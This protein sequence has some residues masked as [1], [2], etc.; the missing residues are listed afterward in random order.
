MSTAEM[1]AGKAAPVAKGVAHP[2]EKPAPAAVEPSTDIIGDM[3]RGEDKR[4][5]FIPVTRQALMERLARQQYWPGNEAQHVRRFFRYLDYWRKQTY[6]A[7][8]LD[9]EQTYEP[10]SPDSDLLI[11][12][13]FNAKEKDGMQTRLVAQCEQLLVQAN[14]TKI[15]P[16]N[17]ELIMTK[18]SHY[19]L[20]LQVDFTAFDELAIYFR[21][22]TM[23]KEHRR[24]IKKLYLWKEE[25]DVPIFQRICIL[26]KM[27]PEER[28]IRDLM[29][30]QKCTEEQATKVVKRLR[31]SLPPQVKPDYVYLKLFKNMPRS[32]VEM[33]FPNTKVKFRL[34]DKMK[35]GATAGSGLGM[36]IFGTA[37]KIAV[38]TNPIA[39]AGA[40]AGLGGIAI[41][42]G[43]NFMNQKTKYMVTMA[44]NLYFHAMADNR[45]VMTLLADRASEEDVKEEIL[46]YSVLAKQT[47]NRNSLAE[48]DKSI[49]QYLLNTFG[50]NLN[51]DVEDALQRL[52]QDGIVTELADGT[53]KT[54]PPAAAAVHI[55]VL[56]DKY[57]D[58]LPD[59]TTTEGVEFELESEATA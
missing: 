58:E 6:S 50:L 55:D 1:T 38:A 36:G 30:K 26:F 22:A 15:D 41:R 18:D 44:Q 20:D 13:K 9:L 23:R 49:E 45:G 32:D 43:I 33:V 25:F 10:F 40:V 57:L 48:V 31:N 12:R 28:Q 52:M 59:M 17:V 37:G 34:F 3:F 47:V 5:K 42:Q 21:G 29:A 39:L 14:Y 35:L 2:G 56:W 46:L 27:K 54:L 19:G 4:E 16:A 11:T 53:L 51:F 7:R 24:N 8:L